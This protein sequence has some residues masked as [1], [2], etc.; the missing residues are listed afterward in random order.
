MFLFVRPQTSDRNRR[1]NR[2]ELDHIAQHWIA[3][4]GGTDARGRFARNRF[5]I[6]RISHVGANGFRHELTHY[7][8]AA[9]AV[10]L[11]PEALSVALR[12]IE[13]VVDGSKLGIETASVDCTGESVYCMTKF[14]CNDPF[15]LLR[16]QSPKNTDVVLRPVWTGYSAEGSDRASWKRSRLNCLRKRAKRSLRGCGHILRVETNV[17]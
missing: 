10:L 17:R 11:W 8:G 4:H 3:V 5:Q 16:F 13:V 9:I 6:V 15:R 7:V 1:G 12:V 2:V 14:M